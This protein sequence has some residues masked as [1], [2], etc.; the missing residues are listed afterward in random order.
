MRFLSLLFLM[1]FS[2]TEL[3]AEGFKGGTLVK[4]P[5]GY[6]AIEDLKVGDLVVS[7][8]FDHTDSCFERKVVKTFSSKSSSLLALQVGGEDLVLD[9]YHQFY[10]PL[11]QIWVEARTLNDDTHLLT[12]EGH[13]LKLQNIEA[14]SEESRVYSISVEGLHNYYVTQQ[15]VLVHNWPP[16]WGGAIIQ[17][18]TAVLT[19][20][21]SVLVATAPQAAPILASPF[22]G[23]IAVGVV[24]TAVA[25]AIVSNMAPHIADILDDAGAKELGDIA[26][27]SGGLAEGFHETVLPKGL[28]DFVNK[29]GREFSHAVKESGRDISVLG[30]EFLAKLEAEFKKELKEKGEKNKPE[31]EKSS[32]PTR[33]QQEVDKGQAPKTIERVD[34]GLVSHE[35]D[36]VHFGDKS[37]LNKDGTWKHGKKILTNQEKDWLKKHNWQIP[38]D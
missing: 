36:H 35:Q 23:A 14:V 30:K 7:C 26:R 13:V 37:A 22:L 25:P 5:D 29:V 2:F 12:A 8:D 32:S 6:T 3:F 11:H 17:G 18:G 24:A 28:R 10:V 27:A 20:G 16:V 9:Q 38:N 33:M 15:D 19:G 31:A 34:K 1:L 21:A 4:V